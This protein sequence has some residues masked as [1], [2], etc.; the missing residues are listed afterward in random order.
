M[1]SEMA[2]DATWQMQPN[3]IGQTGRS[4]FSAF[5]QNIVNEHQRLSC[6]NLPICEIELNSGD[7]NNLFVLRLTK[8]FLASY[9][10]RMH[11]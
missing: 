1:K 7:K 2:A 6:R 11:L 4:I 3:C 8:R 5:P 9:L 10:G